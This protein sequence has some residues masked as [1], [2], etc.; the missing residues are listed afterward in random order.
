MGKRPDKSRHID[1]S[2]L[3]Q[4]TNWDS[5]S[6]KLVFVTYGQSNSVNSSQLGYETTKPVYMGYDG[7]IYNFQEPAIGFVL[8]GMVRYGDESG[9]S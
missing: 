5:N 8:D 1:V 9:T 6:D 7:E 2:K 4:V 3:T